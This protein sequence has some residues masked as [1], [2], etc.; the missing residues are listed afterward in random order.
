MAEITTM[1]QKGQV[2]I[3]QKIRTSLKLKQGTRLLVD[4]KNGLIVMKPFE[5]P[6][7]EPPMIAVPAWIEIFEEAL[8]RT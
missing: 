2:V 3:P 7:L 1:S 8:K 4:I 5:L 6:P